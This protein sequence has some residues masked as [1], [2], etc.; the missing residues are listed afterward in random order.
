MDNFIW[1][2][3]FFL[4]PTSNEK[5]LKKKDGNFPYLVRKSR[6]QSGNDVKKT[7]TLPRNTF[8]WG[9]CLLGVWL[10]ACSCHFVGKEQS[11]FY[12]VKKR[13]IAR[14]IGLVLDE[15]DHSFYVI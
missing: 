11:T 5:D 12:T 1:Y 3:K 8:F 15:K 14:Q 10:A 4:R 13:S 2:N 7:T 6:K 9:V